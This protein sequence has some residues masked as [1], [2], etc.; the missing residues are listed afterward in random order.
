[1]VS[2]NEILNFEPY[3]KVSYLGKIQFFY[4]FDEKISLPVLLVS[5]LVFMYQLTIQKKG[6]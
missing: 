5:T 4:K 1:M 3:F 6:V 2:V